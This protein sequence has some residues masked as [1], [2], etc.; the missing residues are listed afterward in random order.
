MIG[1]EMLET[2]SS[3]QIGGPGCTVEI[4]KG[5]NILNKD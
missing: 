2:S 1:A 3:Y 4:G 5:S